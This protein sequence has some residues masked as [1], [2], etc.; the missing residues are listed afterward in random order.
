[1]FVST[2]RKA[3]ERIRLFRQLEV[4]GKNLSSYHTTL[5]PMPDISGNFG[6]LAGCR[7]LGD[8]GGGGAYGYEKAK[9]T[10]LNS[11]TWVFEVAA[12]S[13]EKEKE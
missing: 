4:V 8:P 10:Y 11:K 9:E 6:K 13:E 12:G 5:M 1:M 3:R 2:F 7:W